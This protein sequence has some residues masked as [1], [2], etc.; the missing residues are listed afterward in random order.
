MSFQLVSFNIV[1]LVVTMSERITA[2]ILILWMLFATFVFFSPYLGVVIP[3]PAATAVYAV[4][5]VGGIVR[6]LLMWLRSRSGT[7]GKS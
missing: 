3:M 7:I 1:R 5:L 6:V 2:G 4:M